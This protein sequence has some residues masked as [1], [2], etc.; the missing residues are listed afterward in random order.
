MIRQPE[1][2]QTMGIA[3]SK[4]INV[5]KND[6]REEK[7]MKKG[8]LNEKFKN[9][10]VKAKL[11]YSFGLIILTTFILIV[12]LLIGMEV[13]EGRLVKL[14][15]G[16]TMNIKYS[17]DLYYPQLDIQRALNRLMAEGVE[18]KDEMYPQL[19]ETINKN[20]LIMGEAITF[21]QGNLLTQ[22]NKDSLN[23]INDKLVNEVTGYREEVLR[24]IE[25]GDYDAAREYNNT[26]YKPAVDEV[27]EMIEELEVSIMNTAAEYESSAATIS[28]IMIIVGVALLIAITWI[29]VKVAVRVTR[30]ILEPVAQIE[31]AAKQLRVGD[32]S[33]GDD[34]NY[35]SE[36]EFGT[37]AKL[38]RE[39]LNIL[40]GYVT[41]ICENFAMVANGD[42]TKNVD[43]I[44]DYLGDFVSL[45]ENFAIILKVYNSALYQI[46]NVSDQVDI[47]SDEVAAAA[48]DLA[49]GTGE[50]ASAV[51]E[52]TA[53]IETVSN[54]AEEAAKE[55]EKA[56]G[57]M[58]ESV[59]EAQDEKEQMQ[60]LQDEMRRIKNI[61]N[62]I[63]MIVTSIE[64]IASQTSLLALNASIEAARA[65]D[66]GRGFTVVADQ[67]GKLASDSAK[68]VVTTKELIGKT[69]EEVDRGNVVTEKTV[70]GFLR[71]IKELENF[72]EAAKANSEVSRTQSAALQQVEQGV[73]QI[74][75]VTQQNAASAEECSAISEELAARSA[76]LD[77]LVNKFKLYQ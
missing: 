10:S 27:K 15:E 72:A 2:F 1:F 35:E 36:D 70:E 29:A 49:S 58:L 37:L 62:E 26:Y 28:I 30:A 16:P 73:E 32:L 5:C 9:W 21:L 33:H 68:A 76:E 50:Q 45:K 64:E 51:E 13:I 42:L 23:N 43:D 59:E 56:Y 12:T 31:T 53:T 67:I 20:L 6:Y 74:S 71:I 19:E 61:S 57:M 4:H 69:I 48:N 63:E 17:A 54:M 14:Y 65:G 40:N 66:A 39:A 25:S 11:L 75:L 38:M 22:E 24:L 41:N 8:T 3:E 52:L 7:H 47:G 77:A 18:C 55:A 34:I 44:P 46:K 60:E